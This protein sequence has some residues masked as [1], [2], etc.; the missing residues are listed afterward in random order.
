MTTVT[1]ATISS[2]LRT[3]SSSSP[4]RCGGGRRGKDHGRTERM[5]GRGP[6][7]GDAGQSEARGQRG[8]GRTGRGGQ[9]REDS[10]RE[11]KQRRREWEAEEENSLTS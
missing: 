9:C 1:M 6:E 4:Q 11:R 8:T 3:R 2:M 7:G 5:P 10:V